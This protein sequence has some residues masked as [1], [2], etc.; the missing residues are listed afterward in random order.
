[1]PAP[2][3]EKRVFWFEDGKRPNVA[4]ALEKHKDII[5]QR[6]AFAG[7]Q[8]D[9]WG[10][11]S[12]SH[13]YC[14]TSARHEV[15]QEYQCNAAL[16]ARCPD[17]IAVST[18]GAGYDT[19]DV[20]ACTAAGI[21]LVNQ[22]LPSGFIPLED[23]GMIYGI[24]QT[25]PG[26]TLEYTNAKCHELQKI[27]KEIDEVTSVSSIAGYEV[28]TEGRG[29][30]AGT[31]I[32]NLKDW[33]ERQHSVHEIIEEL[34]EKTSELGAVIEYFEPPAVPGYGSSDGFSLRLL[35][36]SSTID[37]Q[38]FDKVNW[39]FMHELGKRKELTG[40]FTFFAANYPQYE[41]IIDNELA[42]IEDPGP[43]YPQ[44]YEAAESALQAKLRD[45]LGEQ[46][47]TALQSYMESRGSRMQVDQFRNQLAGADMLRDDQVEPLIAAMHVENTQLRRDLEE[48]RLSQDWN[49]A[50]DDMRREFEE[51]RAELTKEAHDRMHDAAAPIL[52]SSQL[53]KFDA[54]LARDRDRRAAKQRLQ[55]LQVKIGGGQ[56]PPA[57]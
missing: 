30:N 38:E 1:M 51:R 19:V 47:A 17:L 31:C 12:A 53:Q 56:E 43:I 41:L 7:P 22:V 37:Y 21:L 3:I 54:M 32:I 9:N 57:D 4:G 11:M 25:P 44:R 49:D 24:V 48:Y 50:S 6:L 55:G 5:V 52:S 34:E 42:M 39:E 36:K 35:D 20:A 15:P 45:L 10:A 46:K 33:S 14:I 23:Q 2:K 29:S 13:V 27:C 16:I 40:L 28:L 26:S 18:T 8:A